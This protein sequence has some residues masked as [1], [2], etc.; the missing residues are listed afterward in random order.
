[1]ARFWRIP[2]RFG[3]LLAT[4]SLSLLMYVD[5]IA[6][7]TAKE[8]ITEE[9]GLSDTQMGWVLSAFAL[10]YALFQVPGG[11]L[12]DRLGARRALTWVVSAW[13]LFTALTGAI[14]NFVS[15]LIT[16]FLFGLGEAGAYPCVAR[17]VYSWFP[18]KERGIVNGVNFSGS[19]VGAAFSLPLLAWMVT[20]LGWRH[21]FFLW[22]AIGVVW[23]IVWYWWFRD[24]PEQHPSVREEERSY[25]FAH[26][27][28]SAKTGSAFFR[29]AIVLR[30]RQVGLAMGQYFVSNFIFFF[31]LTW[32]YPYLKEKYTLNAAATGWYAMAPLICGAIGNWTS[33]FL[34]DFLY[35]RGH[36]RLSRQLPALIGF[37]L[38]AVGLAV[39]LEA[40]SAP[41]AVL[42]MAV[43]VF[44]ADMTLSPSWSFCTDIGGERAGMVS[45]TM[46]MAGNIGSF[47]TALAFPYLRSWTGTDLPFFYTA[48][49]LALA[50]GVMWLLMDPRRSLS[51]EK[52]AVS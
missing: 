40:N 16:R 1:M 44:G 9:L 15:L 24:D 43:A 22:G 18:V 49:V 7:S 39:L 11:L 46:N 52:A 28:V 35:Q 6:I 36:W 38:T 5:R 25:I 34:V 10:G 17:I 50:G 12:G 42:G 8:P 47:I 26:R 48:M 23:A 4:F 32:L 13:S 30:N 21:T 27:Q 51:D 20:E 14:W 33:G 19:R 3:V 37:L 2:V 41:G 31:C 29:L 45:G